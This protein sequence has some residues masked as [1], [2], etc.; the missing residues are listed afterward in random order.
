MG[1][2]NL[3]FGGNSTSGGSG[4]N[5]SPS[6]GSYNYEFNFNRTERVRTPFDPLLDLLGVDI[7]GLFG[8]SGS[9]LASNPFGGN[10]LEFNPLAGVNNSATGSN[11]PFGGGNSG[12]FGGI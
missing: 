6:T 12:G 8:G 10:P 3:I 5:S 11:N 7:Q 9:N 4:G 2:D 1:D